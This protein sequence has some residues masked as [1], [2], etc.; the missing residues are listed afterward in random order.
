MTKESANLAQLNKKLRT[1]SRKLN[2]HPK[3]HSVRR[4][5]NNNLE[6]KS[7]TSKLEKVK[8]LIQQTEEIQDQVQVIE[9]EKRRFK[10]LLLT[11]PKLYNR[12]RT[13]E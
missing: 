8:I 2:I 12:L 4:K 9:L 5:T 7:S 13:K 11:S 10:I 6:L 1:E 3:I